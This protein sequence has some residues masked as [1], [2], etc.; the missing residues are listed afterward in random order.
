MPIRR[1]RVGRTSVTVVIEEH[2]VIGGLGSSVASLVL[3]SDVRP[4]RFRRI[5]I[6]D[7]FGQSGTADQLWHCYGLDVDS[8]VNDIKNLLDS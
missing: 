2:Q 1:N 8:I 4:T 6:Q 5:G 7:Q 3:E